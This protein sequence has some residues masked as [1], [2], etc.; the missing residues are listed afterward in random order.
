MA[1][2]LS[3]V[4]NFDEDMELA[5][6]LSHAEAEKMTWQ[7]ARKIYMLFNMDKYRLDSLF[8]KDVEEHI[9]LKRQMYTGMSNF[10]GFQTFLEKKIHLKIS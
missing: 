7:S 4:T 8:E 9:D 1:L 3:R 6:A 10:R 2:A 5:L